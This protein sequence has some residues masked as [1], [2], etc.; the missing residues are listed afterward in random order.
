[1]KI[2]TQSPILIFGCR[3]SGTTLVRSL[4][5][6]HPYL[7]VHPQEPQFILNLVTQYEDIKRHK[8]AII[9]TLLTHPYLP[10]SI[11]KQQLTTA[12][13][14][15]TIQSW[16]D[17]FQAYLEVWAGELDANEK[18]VLKD[19]AITFHLEAL[20]DLFPNARYIH[21]VR[22]P[23]GNVSSQRARWQNATVW[24]CANW[25]RDAVKIGHRMAME[26]PDHC[27]EVDY[28]SLVLEPEKNLKQ[29]CH[30]LNIPFINQMLEFQLDTIS[31]SPDA[32]PQP[33]QFTAL[34][35]QRLERWRNYLSPMDVRVI[36]QC[37]KHEMSW[38]QYEIQNPQ[39][40][41][42]ILCWRIAKEWLIYA[43]LKNGR[44]LKHQTRII[45]NRMAS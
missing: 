17:F 3:R 26:D 5:A 45:K 10:E 37:C 19:P 1:M 16:S 24:E 27:L 43:A 36:D 9:S 30:F 35:P 29:I 23:Y 25:W 13:S 15:P 4:L 41:N 28:Q 32:P 33:T 12:L 34:D 22:H 44:K 18:I 6:S 2:A 7:R 21:V 14:D 42:T 38:W 11:D 39:V 31:F 8:K 20:D 40:N